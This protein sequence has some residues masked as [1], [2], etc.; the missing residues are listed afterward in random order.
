MVHKIYW[1]NDGKQPQKKHPNNP[2]KTSST[3]HPSSQQAP[4]KRQQPEMH[5]FHGLHIS[6]SEPLQR[7]ILG[8]FQQLLFAK[9]NWREETDGNPLVLNFWM[10]FL[11]ILSLKSLRVSALPKNTL[12]K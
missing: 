1:R 8:L 9:K 6:K 5:S 4:K 7:S 11:L 12:Y 3:I 10:T 2:Q